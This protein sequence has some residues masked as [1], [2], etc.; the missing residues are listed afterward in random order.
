MMAGQEDSTIQGEQL[1]TP[2]RPPAHVRPRSRPLQRGI[3]RSG[4]AGRRANQEWF[5]IWRDDAI[6][7][8]YRAAT[9]SFSATALL[10]P[11]RLL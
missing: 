10:G 7:G 9:K 2:A 4:H 8:L 11:L 1:E 3:G 5:L 6:V